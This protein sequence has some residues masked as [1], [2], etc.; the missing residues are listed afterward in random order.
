MTGGLDFDA[1]RATAVALVAEV[2]DAPSLVE[3]ELAVTRTLMRI[4]REGELYA[5]E[6]MDAD[7]AHVVRTDWER[8]ARTTRDQ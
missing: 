1:V 6:M 2:L 7:L 5:M 3:A 8:R 4:Y